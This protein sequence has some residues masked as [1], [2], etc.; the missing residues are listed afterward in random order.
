MAF[1]FAAE[2][3]ADSSNIFIFFPKSKSVFVA[4]AVTIR[5]LRCFVFVVKNHQINVHISQNLY[6]YIVSK[7]KAQIDVKNNW[8]LRFYKQQV[9][10]LNI[11][12]SVYAFDSI[13]PCIKHHR[14]ATNKASFAIFKNLT[15]SRNWMINVCWLENPKSWPLI[16]T[17]QFGTFWIR[18]LHS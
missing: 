14:V 17:Y 9:S 5:M 3:V 7:R 15:V 6:T 1:E 13:K 16:G 4:I 12:D 8:S 18:K 2:T 11:E 10:H